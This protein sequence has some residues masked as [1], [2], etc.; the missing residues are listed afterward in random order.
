MCQHLCEAQLSVQVARI[1]GAM[2]G[3]TTDVP[4]TVPQISAGYL[5]SPVRTPVIHQM[6]LN[7]LTDQMFES[8]GDHVFLVVNIHEC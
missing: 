1:N 8:G 6:D 7:A 2:G 4:H 3:K 5:D